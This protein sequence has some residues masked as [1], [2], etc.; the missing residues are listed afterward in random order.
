[1]ADMADRAGKAGNADLADKA[2]IIHMPGMANVTDMAKSKLTQTCYNLWT[3]LSQHM[4]HM[5]TPYE[6]GKRDLGIFQDLILDKGGSENPKVSVKFCQLF[7]VLK[8]PKMA[9]RGR[10]N[11]T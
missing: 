6:S 3:T 5:V 4:N 11:I 8:H 10:P 1:M 7:L 9:I 2:D